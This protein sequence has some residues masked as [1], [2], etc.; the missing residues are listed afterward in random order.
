MTAELGIDAVPAPLPVRRDRVVLE[1]AERLLRGGYSVLLKQA[2]DLAAGEGRQKVRPG[3]EGVAPEVLAGYRE[4]FAAYQQ[5]RTKQLGTFGE[6]ALEL[7]MK[8]LLRYDVVRQQVANVSGATNAP[9]GSELFVAP[10]AEESAT[11]WLE[12]VIAR[13]GREVVVPASDGAKTVLA[14]L[15]ALLAVLLIVRKK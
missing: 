10:A 5:L 1:G 4:L 11:E 3:Y 14:L 6:G 13:F 9:P 7:L 12:R 15:A 2:Y 8:A